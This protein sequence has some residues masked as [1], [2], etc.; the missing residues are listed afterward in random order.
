MQGLSIHRIGLALV[1]GAS[2]VVL[3]AT[4]GWTRT[5]EQ[6]AEPRTD[7]KI[8]DAFKKP[9]VKQFVKRFE[10]EDRENYAQRHEIVAA[11]NLVPG[12]AVADIG[13][14]TGLFTRL[15]AEKVGS[16]GKVYAVDIAPQFLKHIADDAKKRRQDQVLTVLGS[17]DSTNLPRESV[18]LVFL[19]DVY[20]HLEKPEKTLASIHQALRPGGRLVVIEFDRV[21]GKS[22]AFVLKHVRASQAVFRKEIESA[23]FVAISTPNPPRL[24]ENFFLRF[25][26]PATTPAKPVPSR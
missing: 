13:A 3:A 16:T 14:G 26:K 18:D 19:S 1:A 23:G 8:N 17:Q 22:S 4:G 6:K 7:S 9:D 20:H 5:Q 11:L 24:K 2:V 21:E 10:S 15:F 25:E 12:M